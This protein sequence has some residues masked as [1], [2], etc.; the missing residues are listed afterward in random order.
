M[1]RTILAWGGPRGSSLAVLIQ[2]P[3]SRA[4]RNVEEGLRRNWIEVAE[5]IHTALL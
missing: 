3:G 4:A 2:A 1:A 5:E